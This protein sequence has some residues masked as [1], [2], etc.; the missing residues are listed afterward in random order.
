MSHTTKGFSRFT[1]RRYRAVEEIMYHSKLGLYLTY[2]IQAR[3]ITD[4]G[5]EQIEL[6]HNVTVDCHTAEKLAVLFTCYQLSPVYLRDTLE[7]ILPQ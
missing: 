3:R 6:I 5:W 4:Y 7:D 2:G 1:A